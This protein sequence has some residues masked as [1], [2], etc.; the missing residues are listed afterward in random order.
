MKKS[1]AMFSCFL[2]VLMTLAAPGAAFA[3][4]SHSL[5]YPNPPTDKATKGMIQ[6]IIAHMSPKE[7]IGQLVMPSTHDN[8]NEMPNEKTRKLLQEYKA[9]SVIVYGFRDARTTAEYNNQLQQW[10][11]ETSLSVPLF[12]SAD[13]EYGAIQHV[14]GATTFPRQMGIGATGSVDAAENVAAITAEEAKATGFNWNYSPVADVN[15][16]PLNPVIGVRSFGSVTGLVSDMTAAMVNGYQDEGVMATAKHFPGHG[17]TSVDSHLGLAEVTYDM[18]TLRE[19]HLPPFQAAIDAGV[20]SIMTAHVIIEAIDPNLPAT[21]SKEVLTGLLR[22][23]MDFDGIIVTDAMSMN[24]IDENWGSGHAA[25]MAIQAGADIVMATGTYEQ[26]LETFDALLEAYNSGELSKKR[27]KRSLERILLKKFEY[28]LFENRYVDPDEAAE[29]TSAPEHK[30]AAADVAQESITLVKNDGVLP[31]D[32]NADKTTLVAGPAIYGETSYIEDVANVVDQKSAGEVVTWISD[33]TNPT[34]AEI[35]QAVEL[36]GE[37]DR[38]IVPTFSAS[39]LPEGQSELVQA[40][41]ATGKPLAAVSLGLPYDIKN[42][43]DVDAYLASYAVERW[44]SPVPTSWTAAVEVIFGAQPGGTLPVD[45]KGYYPFGHGL[46][47]E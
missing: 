20:D 30:Q 1:I 19:V 40:L 39:Q 15:T 36:A 31:F 14:E 41:E 18:E 4:S 9:G 42:Y 8:A 10:A 32:S 5:N 7:K 33:T 43:P 21:L 38:I 46:Q 2:M 6:R 11:S 22:E 34:N 12:V 26:Q 29:V 28:N 17:D 37:V 23:Q 13:L 44:G 25:V 45:I 47:Y 27:V 3:K 24:A 16:N 35:E